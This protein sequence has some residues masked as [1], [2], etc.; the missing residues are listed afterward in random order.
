[1]VGMHWWWNRRIVGFWPWLFGVVDTS[2]VWLKPWIV[3]AFLHDVNATVNRGLCGENEM[4]SETPLNLAEIQVLERTDR[5]NRIAAYGRDV[6]DN[7]GIASIEHGQ[8]ADLTACIVDLIETGSGIGKERVVL[9]ELLGRLGDPRLRNPD[10]SAYW[11]QVKAKE[12]VS[13]VGRYM[14]TNREF[15]AFVQAGAYENRDIWCDAGW[16]WVQ[17]EEGTW[18]DRVQGNENSPYLVPNQPVVGVTWFEASAYA[19]MHG[20]RLARFDERMWTVRG[21]EKRPYPWGSPFGEGN[22]NTQEEVLGRPCAVGLYTGDKTPEGVFDLAGN[23]AEWC[24]DGADGEFWVH[25]GAWD[26][27]S[28][29]AWAKARILE[30]PDARNAGLGFRLTKA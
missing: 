3:W 2:V 1:M 22:A 14:V 5:V 13:N 8:R 28:M 15:S 10:D 25:P 27:P 20:A 17:S 9:G 23:V 19:R 11:T 4:A 16:A 12:G 18:L 21:V 29:A 7:G 30:R 26:Q 24:G 6:L